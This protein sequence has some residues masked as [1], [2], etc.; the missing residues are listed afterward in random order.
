M[1]FYFYGRYINTDANDKKVEH[2]MYAAI[3]YFQ[4]SNDYTGYEKWENDFEEFFNY[5]VLTSEQKYH[6][7]QMKLVGHAYW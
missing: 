4:S 5:F 3:M 1:G 2:D 6:Y 7:A